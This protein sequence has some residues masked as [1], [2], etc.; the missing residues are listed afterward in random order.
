MTCS[1]LPP[2]AGLTYFKNN[3]PGVVYSNPVQGPLKDCHLI[4]AFSSL[5]WVNNNFFPYLGEK[6]V[7]KYWFYDPVPDPQQY[8]VGTTLTTPMKVEVCVNSAIFMDG[9]VWC[10]ATSKA[11]EL[12]IAMYEKAFAKFCMFK[13]TKKLSYQQLSDSSVNPDFLS[14][15]SGSSWGGNPATV[16]GYLAGNYLKPCTFVVTA[17]NF[18]YNAISSTDVYSFIKALCNYPTS[19]G[20]STTYGLVNGAK[21]RYPMGA[22]TYVNET[23]AKNATNATIVYNNATLSADHCY[24]VLGVYES[25]GSRYIVLRNPYGNADPGISSLGKGPWIYYEIQNQIENLALT[26]NSTRPA[27]AMLDLSPS[28]GI[29]ALDVKVF[30][31]YFEGFGFIPSV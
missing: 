4:T 18:T 28:D 9:T 10:C 21:I 15:T 1:F 19:I 26:I 23:A 12:W 24:S 8:P 3:P 16:L 29:F 7:Y 5:A 6:T 25:N 30:S 13:I 22:W 14:L 20:K 31:Q 17:G 2:P 27:P 11:A